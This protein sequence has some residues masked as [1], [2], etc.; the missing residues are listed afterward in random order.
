MCLLT[1]CSAAFMTFFWAFCNLISA[2]STPSS[3][4]ATFVYLA[5]MSSVLLLCLIAFS[6]L[7]FLKCAFSF[8]TSNSFAA[9]FASRSALVNFGGRFR[10][11]GLEAYIFSK[12]LRLA[13]FGMRTHES[14]L[15]CS[16]CSIICCFCCATVAGASVSILA[17]LRSACFFAAANSRFSFLLESSNLDFRPLRLVECLTLLAFGGVFFL[18]LAA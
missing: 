17:S 1:V 12:S 7:F 11:I 6:S 8:S 18:F 3:N 4:C 15:C 5:I 9:F 10:T 16:S 14:L 13:F 2:C